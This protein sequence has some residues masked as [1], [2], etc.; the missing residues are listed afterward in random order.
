MKKGKGSKGA[1]R[2]STFWL[3]LQILAGLVVLGVL[4]VLLWTWWG[5]RQSEKTFTDIQQQY[6]APAEDLSAEEGNT[7][8]DVDFD[9]LQEEWP[10]VV[11][12]IQW[13][14]LDIDFPIVQGST[15]TQYLRRLPDGTWNNGGS[16]FLEANNQSLLDWH[17]IVYG[18]NMRDGSMFGQLKNYLKE[19]YFQKNGGAA[20]FILYTPDGIWQYDVFS[21]EQVESTDSS[22]YM[23]GFVPSEDFTNFVQEMKDRSLYDMGVEVD[24]TKPVMTL[25]TCAT[26]TTDSDIRIVVHG[27]QG[28]QLG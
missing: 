10:D 14:L 2:G 25:S 19:E 24:G 28:Q 8:L 17:A 1:S 21:I 3:I 13:P 15:N 12:W 22:V 18:H 20:A 4:G 6:T 5:Y 9:A 26:S 23:V 27:V 7:L 16:I 11:G